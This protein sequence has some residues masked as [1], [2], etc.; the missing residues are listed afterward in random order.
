MKRY[1]LTLRHITNNTKTI[2]MKNL[3]LTTALCFIVTLSFA[4]LKVVAP[5]GDVGIGTST[6][7]E[8]L[9]VDGNMNII[10]LG[11]AKLGIGENRTSDGN[12]FIDL[13]G[14]AS[15]YSD[16]GFRF[17][18]WTNGR[19]AFVH[20]GTEPLSFNAKEGANMNFSQ[21]TSTVMQ[22]S[23]S[24]NLGVGLLNA[25]D[26]IAVNGDITA[27]GT[28]TWSDARLK[29]NISSFDLGLAELMQIEPKSY[30][31]NGDAGI[32]SKIS[33]VGVLAQEFEKIVPTAVVERDYYVEDERGEVTLADTYKGVDEKVIV[34]LM[35]NSIK[36]QQA[37]IEELTKQL[38]ALQTTGVIDNNV[39]GSKTATDFSQKQM[40]LSN[41]ESMEIS[42]ISPNPFTQVARIDYNLQRDF[43][44]ATVTVYD[45]NG[46][47]VNQMQLDAKI[48]TVEI[49]AAQLSE[50]M[51]T[52]TIQVDGEIVDTKKFIKE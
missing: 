27:T 25:V 52:Y 12:A 7:N 34:Y 39:G 16:Y 37:Q 33:H 20:R 23:P 5:N 45:V 40:V 15:N 24:G 48:G 29:S 1:R 3:I 26:A 19:S 21:G 10:G 30:I 13:V 51:Y 46:Q 4:Q 11:N 14:D 9:E 42:K 18:R 43:T 36:E 31:Y 49:Q 38:A 32:K 22:L 35:V 2:K 44:N 6:P 8:K 28:V 17:T 41:L 47:L 50:G